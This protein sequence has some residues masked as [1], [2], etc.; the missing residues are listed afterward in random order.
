MQDAFVHCAELVRDADRDRY[1]AAL[2]APA[3]RREALF[4]LYAFNVEVGRVREAAREPLPG[5]IRLQ[6]WRDVLDGERGGEAGANPVAAALLRA[7]ERHRLPRSKLLDLIEARR[8]DLYDEP[9]VGIA[10]LEDYAKRTSSTVIDIAAQILGADAQPAAD[11]A[12]IAYGIVGL[13]RAFP[14]HAARHQ[15]YVPTELFERHGIPTNDVFA[16]RSSAGLY[17]ALAEL[18]MLARRHL[19]TACQRLRALPPPAY[20]AFLPLTVVRPTL[21]RLD[22]SNAFAPADISPWRRQW[23]IWRA[24]HNPARI[25]R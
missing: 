21:D 22:R 7:I 4:A 14:L 18:R 13:M 3:E 9:M 11:S 6:W 10:D 8:F 17:A 1:L 20:P 23:L 15:L 12:G 25:A 19:A 2:F 16:G 5:E 24:A